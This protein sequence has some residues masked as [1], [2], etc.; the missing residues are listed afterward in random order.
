MGWSEIDG[1]IVA[2]CVQVV[3]IEDAAYVP[4]GCAIVGRQAVNWMGQSPETRASSLVHK[5]SDIFSFRIVVSLSKE[6][7]HLFLLTSHNIVY[8]P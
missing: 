8:M 6:T 7:S 5:L 3:D 4:D 1:K 2:D